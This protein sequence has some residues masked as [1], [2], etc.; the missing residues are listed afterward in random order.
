MKTLFRIWS[1]AALLCAVAAGAFAQ[2]RPPVFKEDFNNLYSG[3]PQGWNNDSVV[4]RDYTW[5]F[6]SS[7]MS[8]TGC[9]SYFAV[10]SAYSENML[11]TPEI[12][13]DGEQM[14]SF[15]HKIIQDRAK[16][17]VY[18]SYDGGRTFSQTPLITLN[19]IQN[20]S[21]WAHE[22]VLLP[23]SP[24][25]SLTLAF[26]A[27]SEA[28]GYGS[29]FIYLDNVI[30]DRPPRCAAPLDFELG[31]MTSNSVSL[32]WSYAAI[33]STGDEVDVMIMK[34]GAVVQ[35]KTYAVE[36]YGNVEVS[37]LEPDT[38]YGVKIRTN[39]EESYLGRSDWSDILEFKTMCVP[40]KLPLSF[41][42]DEDTEMSAC[43]IAQRE[44]LV[45]KAVV[46]L[47]STV[48]YGGSGKSLE[49][50]KG[51]KGNGDT[52]VFTE[53][54]DH[55]ANDMEI[56]LMA[57]SYNDKKDEVLE[58]GIQGDV[59]KPST[60]CRLK[61]VTLKPKTWTHIVVYTDNVPLK[62]AKGASVVMWAK[63][64]E[65]ASIFVDDLEVNPMPACRVPDSVVMTDL[66]VDW[67]EFDWK[68]E[69]GVSLNVYDVPDG[70]VETLVGTLS[71][72]DKRLELKENTHYTLRFKSSC[73]GAD[74]SNWGTDVIEVITP[75]KPIDISIEP[76]YT[77]DFEEGDMPD[78]WNNVG[79]TMLDGK[80]LEWS[81]KAVEGE[82][83][84]D[85]QSKYAL[86]S[87]T[88]VAAIVKPKV[89]LI[90]P[91]MNIPEANEYMVEFY[92]YRPDEISSATDY[93]NVYVNDRQDTVNARRIGRIARRSTLEPVTEKTGWERY[94][95]LIPVKGELYV[96]L[97][98]ET[99]NGQTTYIDNVSVKK[100]SSC[101][102]P[103]DLRLSD[104][105]SST[106]T[107]EW[108]EN[109][110]AQ[111]YHVTYKLRNVETTDTVRG[112]NQYTI[113]GL[114]PNTM[115]GW[116]YVTVKV[117]CGENDTSMVSGRYDLSTGC[118]MLDLPYK[119]GGFTD[120]KCFNVLEKNGSYP[121][122][123]Q[124]VSFRGFSNAVA[125]PE[126][127][128]TS[129]DGYRVEFEYMSND[130]GTLEIGTVP[131]LSEDWA[132]HFNSVMTIN[133]TKQRTAY[134]VDITN[135]TDKYIVL[136]YAGKA[137]TQMSYV[138]YLSVRKTPLCPDVERLDVVEAT[139]ST[140]HLNVFCEGVEKV[141]IEYGI[142][143]FKRGT[144]KM[145]EDVNTDFTLEDLVQ[146][147]E[148]DIYVRPVCDAGEGDWNETPYTFATL[149][150]EIILTPETP[151]KN[152]FE[153]AVVNDLGCWVCRG[154]NTWALGTVASNAYEGSKYAQLVGSGA[155]TYSDLY[156]AMELTAGTQYEFS[157]YVMLNRYTGSGFTLSAGYCNGIGVGD[158]QVTNFISETPIVN[159]TEYVKLTAL[160]TPT[161]DAT[162]L[163][164]RGVTNGSQCGIWLDNVFVSPVYCEYPT[165][166]VS[167]ISD[168]KAVISWN[169]I[170]VKN[171]NIKVAT[172]E[173]TDPET[174][175]GDVREITTDDATISEAM[176]DGLTADTEYYVYMQ[177]VCTDGGKSRW[178]DVMTF[179]TQC[180]AVSGDFSES[181]EG[182]NALDCWRWNDQNE[183]NKSNTTPYDGTSCC[184][185]SKSGMSATLVTPTLDVESLDGKMLRMFVKSS[186]ASVTLNIG[187]TDVPVSPI[188]FYP[189]T[190][191][192]VTS[193]DGWKEVIC[194]F[195]DTDKWGEYA[196]AKN[197]V[198]A[199][200]D[201]CYIDAVS[202]TDI[203]SCA[204]PVNL[205]V[206]EVTDSYAEIDWMMY[207]EKP[208]SVI[209]KQ[210]GQEVQQLLAESHP[211]RI[212]NLAS[213]TGYEVEIRTLCEEA[214]SE[215]NSIRF[216]TL[217][218]TVPFPFAESFNAVKEREI[219]EC[220]VDTAKFG[221]APDNV[222]N[223]WRAEALY[224]GST[225]DMV[226]T[227]D[228]TN[229]NPSGNGSRLQTP[230]IDLTGQTEAFLYFSTCATVED[231]MMSVVVSTDGGM[232]FPDTIMKNV[233]YTEWTNMEYDLKD[234]CGKEIAIG[235]YGVSIYK[236]G[237]YVYIDNMKVDRQRICPVP[238]A[239]T[240]TD[241]TS[242]SANVTWP[243]ETG[244]YVFRMYTGD[245]KVE[246]DTVTGKSLT[247]GNLNPLTRYT[248]KV[249]GICN[250]GAESKA[251]TISFRTECE[252]DITLPYSETFEGGAM[253]QC[254]V[255]E[256]N[257]AARWSYLQESGG[258]GV[259]RF[260]SRSAAAG[261]RG[262]LI[263]PSI[264]IDGTGYRLTFDYVNP[265]GGPLSVML[266][267]DGGETYTDT[268]LNAVRDV[269]MWRTV[270]VSLDGYAGGEVALVAE[271]TSNNSMQDGAYI[272]LDNL[273]VGRVSETRS[274]SD[275]VCHGD[276]YVAHGFEIPGVTGYGDNTLQRIVPG[277]G[278][279]QP[280][281]LY[282]VTL[283]VPNTDYYITDVFV[284]GETYTGNGFSN[285]ITAPGRDYTLTLTSSRGCD[286]T[287]HLALIEMDV[288]V[289]VYDTICEGGSYTFCGEELTS[290]CTRTCTEENSYGVDSTT[291][292]YLTVLPSTVER[293]DTI[294]QGDFI[295]FGGERRTETG[296]YT[297]DS[298][299][300][301]GC[302]Y[303]SVLNLTV[304]DS[305]EVREETVCA[306]GYV[307]ID[308]VRYTESG[309][310][311]VRLEPEGGCPRTLLL[312]LTVLPADTAVHRTVACEGSPIYYPGFAGT[313]V[314]GDTV[315]FRTAKTAGGCDSVTRLEVEYRETVEVFDT[316]YC[317]E[318]VYT[319]DNGETLTATGD[320]ESR[321]K[322][323]DGCDSI[324]HLHVEFTTGLD[325]TGVR[326]LIITPNPAE[327][328]MLAYADGE[329]TDAET[330][331]MTV[332]VTDLSGRTLHRG[333]V[334]GRPI[335]IDG[336]TAAG[337]YIVRVT[338]RDGRVY[339][340]RLIVE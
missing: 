38:E 278:A 100:K 161:A 89:N 323:A 32:M 180:A 282:E 231:A 111:E 257:T 12:K 148:Y 62:D 166:V 234:Y 51:S 88:G 216:T 183:V 189:V 108:T 168:T 46:I 296:T 336:L 120:W 314:T 60:Y 262:R 159:N 310:H 277:A 178:T 222:N 244:E 208:C 167:E 103:T 107:I 263:S 170:L 90:L 271:G 21:V 24:T 82:M 213:N 77:A 321:D 109:S 155:R 47:S 305:V 22:D 260:N 238:T 235:F 293:T 214:E 68:V 64:L 194:H 135:T 283:H 226:M 70:G 98:N 261:S 175:T 328:M 281:T 186:D 123:S 295:D 97:E 211:F 251:V 44:D 45:S 34:D 316:V 320:C 163:R 312:S 104:V 139:V 23:T 245:E 187:V 116:I 285:G 203:P 146:D 252:S 78:C 83:S 10:G 338:A 112:T 266:T 309:S 40:K 147:T 81:V 217:C 80:Y 202:V 96:I 302:P 133:G 69:S 255:D 174:E 61:E 325:V 318:K 195:S 289:R 145:L 19:G 129:A 31:G 227:F 207:E 144:G 87:P 201:L 198:I 56:S 110:P 276:P 224:S 73:G 3:I 94:E 241:V 93:I 41:T 287:V 239:L 273:R 53:A 322:T 220:W 28:S 18:L 284:P 335:R 7:G 42:F 172:H 315:L 324:R 247:L 326:G 176:I 254:W 59:Y 134:M 131:A 141:D 191:F 160:F 275:T 193:G 67:A 179:R 29:P 228:G 269:D 236:S 164:I 142:R 331:G 49:I 106:A 279:G 9:V 136:K 11:V 333:A 124:T 156:Y 206:N 2:V 138:Y 58:I 274:F 225:D 151:F 219:P 75:C 304:I 233:A 30:I 105:G 127:N 57:Y 212:E 185:L 113:T 188:S 221:P 43:W 102:S 242:N 140:A 13:V 162:H 306:G 264:G 126:F 85:G 299:Y 52:Y 65:V 307:E 121:S 253:P 118:G 205:L 288:D 114:T 86:A 48:A 230:V 237:A 267:Q 36:S 4:N 117:V 128:Y 319:C 223:K 209:V 132:N 173:L 63:D 165:V 153:D 258:N 76:G 8:N 330:E 337:V 229:R 292:L 339:T 143:G 39:C 327:I 199:S 6:S 240:V 215:A 248:I 232:T 334:T 149:C 317:S 95:C 272:Y 99:Y 290:G 259:M 66:G 33:G 92:I 294:C 5:K 25:G 137:G 301:G 71:A 158:D 154:D 182:N 340:G 192:T 74:E 35:E 84:F 256:S 218:G 204:K 197:I 130:E 246:E 91:Y 125:L 181:F 1:L 298:T 291:T 270:S 196:D 122:G 177:S 79:F 37:G 200:D 20:N 72:S 329:W 171:Y 27:V 332:E 268:V 17:I 55:A 280:D 54:I 286:S 190:T 243:S 119:L 14:L 152:G 26:K 303:T 101:M 300:A 169:Q 16:L 311:R 15:D 115:Y 265:A 249:T 308:G 150:D 250:D 297:A 50:Q 157:C 210:E 184:M 313:V